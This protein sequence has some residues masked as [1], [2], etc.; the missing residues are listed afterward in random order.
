MRAL[1]VLGLD[2][3]ADFEAIRA[4][5]RRLAKASHPDV[6]PGDE[7]AATRFRQIQA[8]Y[9]V[10]RAAEDRRQWKPTA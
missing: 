5:W 7:E 3:D 1:G 2:P 8:S 9:E 6:K 4:A 10:L